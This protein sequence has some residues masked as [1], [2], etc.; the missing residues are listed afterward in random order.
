MA[1][2]LP[3]DLDAMYTRILG[4]IKSNRRR[5]G[6]L[7][8]YLVCYAARTLTVEQL[9]VAVS[10]SMAEGDVSIKRLSGELISSFARRVNAYTCGL[11]DVSYHQTTESRSAKIMS[12]L[13]RDLGY[14]FSDQ[15]YYTRL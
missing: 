15:W 4:R 1:Q 11:S 5:E 9:F 8:L 2:S 13:F 3:T 10:I 12:P 14:G 6:S 7:M